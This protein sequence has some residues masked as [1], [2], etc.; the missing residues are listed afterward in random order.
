MVNMVIPKV[1]ALGPVIY[2]M[3]KQNSTGFTESP[4][5]LLVEFVNAYFC[6]ECWDK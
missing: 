1:L 3:Y 2:H 4:L 6:A 5:T